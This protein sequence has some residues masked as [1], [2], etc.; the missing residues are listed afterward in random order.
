MATLTARDRVIAVTADQLAW[1][2]ENDHPTARTGNRYGTK[3]DPFPCYAH[4]LGLV[5]GMLGHVERVLEDRGAALKHKP[6]IYVLDREP[7]ARTNGWAEVDHR[8]YDADCT[9][10]CCAD[11]TV[12]WDGKIVLAGKRIPPHPG[13]TRY[14]VA[15]E[16]GHHV[17]YELLHRRDLQPGDEAVRTE[18][19]A[20]RGLTNPAYYGGGT[21]HASPGEVFANDFRILVA[22]IEPEYWPH[23]GISHPNTEPDVATWWRDM[24]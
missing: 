22:G 2:F 24:L 13:V 23:P 5:A 17:E 9:E 15:H 16:Y 7:L 21:W 4:D 3:V 19:A 10:P 14:L 20:I 6:T 12:K 18:Y 8:Y 11:K 1:R